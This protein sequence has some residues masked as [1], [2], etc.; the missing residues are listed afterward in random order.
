M[1]IKNKSKLEE[2]IYCN[3]FISNMTVKEFV[4]K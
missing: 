2:K 1:T 3:S 4:V